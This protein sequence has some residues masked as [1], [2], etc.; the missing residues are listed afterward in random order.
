MRCSFVHTH[1][2]LVHP[3]EEL[4]RIILSTTFGTLGEVDSLSI[5]CPFQKWANPLPGKQGHFLIV[6]GK[7]VRDNG[8]SETS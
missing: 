3:S 7:I 6:E 5:Y 1:W 8:P 2:R 4:I